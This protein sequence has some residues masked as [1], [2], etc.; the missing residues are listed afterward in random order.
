MII[1]LSQQRDLKAFLVHIDSGKQILIA[2]LFMVILESF[3]LSL[4]VVN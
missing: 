1:N 4:S 2:A 3:I